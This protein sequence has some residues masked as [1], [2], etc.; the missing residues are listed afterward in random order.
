[1]LTGMPQ[2]LAKRTRKG[3]LQYKVRW[4]N[5]GEEADTWEPLDNLDNAVDQIKAYHDDKEAEKEAKKSACNSFSCPEPRLKNGARPARRE[6]AEDGAQRA[7]RAQAEVG[8]CA[9]PLAPCAPRIGPPTRSHGI[10]MGVHRA[11]QH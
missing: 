1:M 9:H 6:A 10:C 3:V 7:Q 2:V 4:K 5:Y 11:H 8:E